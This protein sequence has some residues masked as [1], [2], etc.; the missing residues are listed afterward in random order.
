VEACS[1]YFLPRI[2]GAGRALSLVTTGRTYAAT[3]AALAGIFTEVVVP[4]EVR[5]RALAVADEIAG[6]VSSKCVFVCRCFPTPF[7]L[8]GEVCL[9]GYISPKILRQ[10]RL[11]PN[12][13]FFS[14]FWKE[15]NMKRG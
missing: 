13:C 3:D 9:S 14:S 2:V 12:I 7:C 1:S 5:P 8:K 4:G 15:K 6:Q 11:D 10:H